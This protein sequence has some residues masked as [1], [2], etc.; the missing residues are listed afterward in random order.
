M[1]FTVDPSI[2]V[3]M[4]DS[5]L[6]PVCSSITAFL[7]TTT[8]F[9]LR[10]IFIIFNSHSLFSNGD[11]SF[12]GL[13]STSEPGRN[14]IIPLTV[15]LKPPLTLVLTYPLTIVPSF[16]ASSRSIHA[17]ICLAFTLDRIVDP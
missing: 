11:V 13:M 15:T 12:T 8:L 5:R 1:P 9:L 2:S 10:S 7:E 6:V 16:I 17:C 14:A 3:S 4:T